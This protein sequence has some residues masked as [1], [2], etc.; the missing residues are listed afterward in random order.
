M[1]KSFEEIV[2]SERRYINSKL[3]KPI[4]T[5]WIY[6]RLDLLLEKLVEHTDKESKVKL[7]SPNGHYVSNYQH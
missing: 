6:F 2:E 5:V 4:S 3:E 1:P 7:V